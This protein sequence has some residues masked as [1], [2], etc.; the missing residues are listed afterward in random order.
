MSGENHGRHRV[1]SANP[2]P[3]PRPPD[4]APSRYS[5]QAFPPYRFVPGLLPH[6]RRDPKGHSF[7]QPEPVADPVAPEAWRECEPYL[8][9]IDLYNYAYWWECHEQLEA[10]WHAVGHDTHQGQFLQGLVQIAAANLRRFMDPADPEAGCSL[11]TKGLER[12]GICTGV[13]MGIDVP[14]F[15]SETR[16]Y[17]EGTRSLPALIALSANPLTSDKD[18]P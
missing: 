16:A 8:Y 18:Q 17:F 11:A 7:G 1:N 15:C 9:A 12:L 14:L 4:P 3:Q 5:G 6:P 10:L 13:F 2:I